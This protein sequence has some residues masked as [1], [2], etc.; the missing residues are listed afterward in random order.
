MATMRSAFR[1]PVSMRTRFFVDE[2]MRVLA[3][4]RLAAALAAGLGLLALAGILL[5]QL[6]G[7]A[8]SDPVASAQWLDGQRGA[9]GPA[10]DWMYRLGLYDVFHSAWMAASFGLLALS[11]VACTG[12]R[13][14]PTWRNVVHPVKAVP[15]SFLLSSRP[16]V[17]R[18]PAA[19]PVALERAMRRR[20]FHV[21]RWSA[22]GVEWLFADRYPWAQLATF[23]SHAAI[24]LLLAGALVTHFGAFTTR[25]FVAEGAS[26]PVFPIGHAPAMNVTVASA[27]G[28]LDA[29]G[30]SLDAR[31][32]ISVTTNGRTAK[33]CTITA[34]QPC[35]WDGYRI[36]QAFFYSAGVDL[37]VRDTS[38]GRILF[39]QAVALTASREAPHVVVSDAGGRVLLDQVVAFTGSVDGVDGALLAIP[40]DTAP[41]WVGLAHPA[42]G[43][44]L[45]VF[46]PG[47]GSQ[48]RSLTVPLHASAPAGGLR[49]EFAGLETTPAAELPGL[50]APG[51]EGG[52]PPVAQLAGGRL[53]D[54]SAA[55]PVLLLSGVG[56]RAVALHE[57]ERAVVGNLEYQFVG[58]KPFVGLEVRKDRG[59][60]LIW[61]GS[62][63]LVLGLAAT[64]WI[65]RRRIWAR[66][67]GDGLQMAGMAPKFADLGPEFEA[68]AAESATAGP[69]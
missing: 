39:R 52:I 5:P 27:A 53:S 9:L 56:N 50:P 17:F 61:I 8:R 65:P 18:G 33:T 64:L 7:A 69:P 48:Q 20:H 51:P 31:S 19:D 32:E 16:G 1:S 11:V 22:N 21:E 41:V 23:V 36:R 63:M 3:S 58:Q 13:F 30:R 67:D 29:H 15:E 28:S 14:A 44:A 38:D 45:I 46:Q 43:P 12:R 24:V 4:V 6:P 26:A 57:G 66:T 25:L 42:D 54:G 47:D 68:L 10:A 35:T 55:P 40:G 49:F 60:P 59:E 37:Q 34:S 2:L 62:A